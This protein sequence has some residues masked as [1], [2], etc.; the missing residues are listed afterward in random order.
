VNG[1]LYISNSLIN[2]TTI[3]IKD[4]NI[5]TSDFNVLSNHNLSVDGNLKTGYSYIETNSGSFVQITGNVIVTNAIWTIS[6]SSNINITGCL[7]MDNV[8]I[9]VYDDGSGNR[10]LITYNVSCSSNIDISAINVYSDS[11]DDCTETT[12]TTHQNNFVM[13]ISL[14]K[15]KKSNFCLKL[16]LWIIILI[17]LASVIVLSV[18]IVIILSCSSLSKEVFPFRFSGSQPEVL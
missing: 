15:T 14:E 17:S 1:G 11:T 6:S 10:D 12:V 9:N 7:T 5:Q 13:T 4:I 2:L 18:L 8:T 16:P 3:S